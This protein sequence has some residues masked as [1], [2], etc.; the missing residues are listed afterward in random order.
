M[1]TEKVVDLT[2][3]AIAPQIIRFTLPLIIGNFFVL[4]YNAVD[5]IVVG[6]FIG[7]NALAAVGAASPIMNI[8]LFLIIGICLGMSV[9]MGN[10]F[11]SGDIK[12]LKRVISTS[13]IAGGFFYIV[14]CCFW[15]FL[16]PHDTCIDEYSSCN[17]RRG[18]FIFADYF[19]WTDFYFYL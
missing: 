17:Y 3:G 15:F 10:F 14:D 1:H 8:M 12:K 11:G 7:A 18:N 6:R 2:R 5:A 9:L 13:I 16:Y 19:C 4:T